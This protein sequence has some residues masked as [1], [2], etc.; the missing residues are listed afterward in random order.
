LFAAL[1]VGAEFFRCT[2][3]PFVAAAA[4]NLS[5]LRLVASSA[6]AAAAAPVGLPCLQFTPL[7]TSPVAISTLL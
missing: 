1:L 7:P 4:A 2:F 5:T 3:K 6:A